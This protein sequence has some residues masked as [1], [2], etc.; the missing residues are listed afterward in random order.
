MYRSSGDPPPPLP[1]PLPFTSCILRGFQWQKPHTYLTYR[2][3]PCQMLHYDLSMLRFSQAV[4]AAAVIGILVVGYVVLCCLLWLMRLT[5]NRLRGGISQ[6]HRQGAWA[7]VTGASRGIGAEFA[8]DLASRGFNGD[9]PPP[10]SPAPS[11]NVSV[12]LLARDEER[13]KA[14][15][16]ELQ[17]KH[18][19]DVK[20]SSFDFAAPDVLPRAAAVLS[21]IGINSI[22]VLINNVG[23]LSEIPE[24]YLDH[25]PGY[26]DRL[27]RVRPGSLFILGPS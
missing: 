25:S 14:L 20:F 2:I 7:V 10:V 17:E 24:P 11:D 23:Y 18:G 26:V 19:V 9:P 6:F 4:D 15:Q 5:T 3:K 27:I 21:T 16:V 13:M 12:F 1:N 22:S 8:R